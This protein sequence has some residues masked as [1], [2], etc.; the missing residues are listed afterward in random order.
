MYS[1]EWL[2]HKGRY[3]SFP[4]SAS[5][6]YCGNHQCTEENKRIPCPVDPSHTV[7]ETSLK[8]HVIVCNATKRKLEEESQ[9]YFS[10]DINSGMY[11]GVTTT[12][13]V[14]EAIDDEVDENERLFTQG[15]T[16][17]MSNSLK[18]YLVSSSKLDY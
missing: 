14:K 1:R 2:S 6:L 4:R 18:R 10:R 8:S 17:K 16:T 15:L 7:R 13:E 3:C 5:S 9:S 12:T 11:P